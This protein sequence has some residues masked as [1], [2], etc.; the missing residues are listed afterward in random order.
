MNS[1]Q[2]KSLEN[3]LEKSKEMIFR[4]EQLLEDPIKFE[5]ELKVIDSYLETIQRE[6]DNT[7]GL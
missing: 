2:R 1:N 3:V 4:V 7:T 6:I 5:E